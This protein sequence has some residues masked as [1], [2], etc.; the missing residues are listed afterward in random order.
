MAQWY[1]VNDG[2]EHGPIDESEFGA[3]T[4]S[5]VVGPDTLVWTDTMENWEPARLHVPGVSDGVGTSA[6]VVRPA[7]PSDDSGGRDYRR[8]S[9]MKDALVEFFRRYFDFQGRSNR[10]E[11]W[12]L[13]L[14]SI[15]I[16]VVLGVV[17]A[18]LF[19]DVGAN[20]GVLGNIWSLAT[21]IPSIALSVRRLHDIDKSGWWLLL[22]LVPVI[23][24]LVLI[25]WHCQVPD[26]HPNRFG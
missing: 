8:K 25:Y 26:E 20:Y 7:V 16:G 10:G 2:Q 4:R 18:L 3:L 6:R 14:D 17:D 12:W 11:F 13:I 22:A 19:G 1:Y 9:G 15:I 23:G 21:L 5:G 24:W